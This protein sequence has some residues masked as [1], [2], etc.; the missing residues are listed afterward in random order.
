[1][2][3]VT[4]TIDEE[5]L[6]WIDKVAQKQELDR[7]KIIRQCIE[8]Q[9]EIE[10]AREKG[11]DIMIPGYTP[12]HIDK[13]TYE[14]LE[15]IAEIVNIDDVNELL[16]YVITGMHAMLKLGVWRFL[17]P[18]PELAEEAMKEIEQG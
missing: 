9:M 8:R 17:K 15:E 6:K 14:L 16:E 7:S 2:R 10:T 4:F 3:A 12:L 18:L 11:V 1:M 5:Q 13:K